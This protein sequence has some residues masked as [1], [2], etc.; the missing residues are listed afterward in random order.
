MSVFRSASSL[1]LN[2]GVNR[3]SFLSTRFYFTK[4]DDVKSF[5]KFL[6]DNKSAVVDFYADWCG[7][8]R[9]MNPVLE[10]TFNNVKDTKLAKLDIDKLPAIAEEF[11]VSSIPTIIGFKDGKE[12]VRVIGAVNEKKLLDLIE[13]TK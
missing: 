11:G 2:G 3:A 6:D 9:M 5:D 7:P 1:F 8:C 13:K 4:A 12:V 10:K